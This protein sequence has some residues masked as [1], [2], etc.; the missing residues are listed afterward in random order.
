MG[1]WRLGPPIEGVDIQNTL[2]KTI[3]IVVDLDLGWRQAPIVVLTTVQLPVAQLHSTGMPLS[4]SGSVSL[5]S[6]LVPT[7]PKGTLQTATV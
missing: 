7:S 3:A 2:D 6:S 5:Q 4:T 1:A